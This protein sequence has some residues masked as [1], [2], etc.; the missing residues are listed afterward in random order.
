[1]LVPIAAVLCDERRNVSRGGRPIAPA[2]VEQLAADLREHG[3]LEPVGVVA[4]DAATWIEDR[5][6]HAANGVRFVL[7]YGYRRHAAIRAAGL[8]SI[9]AIDCGELTEDAADLANLAENWQRE[10]P[11]EYDLTIAVARFVAR[12]IGK[13]TIAARIQRSPSWV[14]ECSWIVRRVAPDLLEHYRAD[15]RR[16]TR[17]KMIALANIEGSDE[18]ARHDD[19]RKTW[20][21]WERAAAEERRRDPDAGIRSR[22]R[23]RRSSDAPATRTELR[24]AIEAVALARELFDGAGWRPLTDDARAALAQALRW[25]ARPGEHPWR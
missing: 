23:A 18:R 19:Q 1:M 21:E 11:T 15:T 7:V 2:S 20:A 3:Q 17:R 16:E 9:L 10:P 8:P 6:H 24:E 13:L 22:P 4:L 12:K 5:D 25:A 14:E